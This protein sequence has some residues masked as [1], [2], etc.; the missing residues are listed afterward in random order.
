MDELH[1]AQ[2]KVY[3]MTLNLEKRGKNNKKFDSSMPVIYA[4]TPTYSRLEQKAELTRLA[5]TFLHLSNFHWIVVEDSESKT[6][7]V[8]NFLSAC[9]ISY[10]HLN[11][12]TPKEVKLKP[13][14]PN[15]LKPRGV[16]QRNLGLSWIRKNLNPAKQPGVVYFADDDNTYDLRIFAEVI[17]TCLHL[18][19]TSKLK[20]FIPNV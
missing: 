11:I 8:T 9:G 20:L 2:K 14:D 18:K 19:R 12:V 7:L 1:V 15:W 5:Q 3:E 6:K 16:L 17:E 13:D 4:I 10:T